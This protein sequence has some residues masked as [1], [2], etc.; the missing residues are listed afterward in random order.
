[1][2]APAALPVRGCGSDSAITGWSRRRS[3]FDASGAVLSGCTA[4]GGGGAATVAAGT[5]APGCAG[6]AG[7]AAAGVAGATGSMRSRADVRSFKPIIITMN[8]GLVAAIA[9]R[10]TCA[11]S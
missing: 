11:Q 5:V 10:I 1:M 6:L 8:F 7:D 3:A 9:S 2:R 4:A